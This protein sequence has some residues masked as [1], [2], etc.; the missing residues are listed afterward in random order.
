MKRLLLVLLLLSPL[1]LSCQKQPPNLTPLGAAEF[2]A[3]Q[4]IK[5][6]SDFQDAIYIAYKADKISKDNT[7]I[8]TEIVGVAFKVIHDAPNGAQ[9]VALTALTEIQS[10]LNTTNDFD[11]IIEYITAARN[12]IKG[13]T[14]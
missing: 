9:S 12:V 1:E 14:Q 4:Y 5:A 7:H 6:L 8:I 13:L 2:K 11:L 3:D 10:K